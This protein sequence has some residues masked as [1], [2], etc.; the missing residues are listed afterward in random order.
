MLYKSIADANI[1]E[2]CLQDVTKVI[3]QQ[4]LQEP[5]TVKGRPDDI[6]I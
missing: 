5:I 3:C 1:L 6:T 2:Q 4:Q